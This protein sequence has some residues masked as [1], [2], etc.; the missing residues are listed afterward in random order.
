MWNKCCDFKKL[1]EIQFTSFKSLTIDL[2]IKHLTIFM[3]YMFNLFF[4][5]YLLLKLLIMLS[6]HKHHKYSLFHQQQKYRNKK[7]SES[8][9]CWCRCTY[10]NSDN[11]WFMIFII[12]SIS[13]T[14][15]LL[16]NF[17]FFKDFIPRYVTQ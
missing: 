16:F 2:Y 3:F 12:C 10:K 5:Y 11:I 9:Q 15:L 6:Y 13:S 17:I 14:Q 4:F 7:I 8:F 1:F